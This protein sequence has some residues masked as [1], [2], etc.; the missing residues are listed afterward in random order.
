MDEKRTLLLGV[1]GHNRFS[2]KVHMNSPLVFELEKQ[3]L[4][5]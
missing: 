3:I 5:F 1:D 2:M 4:D